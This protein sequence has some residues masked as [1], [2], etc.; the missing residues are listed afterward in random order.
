MREAWVGPGPAGGKRGSWGA[1]VKRARPQALPT[2]VPPETGVPLPGPRARSD[3]RYF[4]LST[5]LTSA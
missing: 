4:C 5:A 2:H 1:E 3:C